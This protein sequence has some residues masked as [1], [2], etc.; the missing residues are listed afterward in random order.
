MSSTS[1]TLSPPLPTTSA[2]TRSADASARRRARRRAALGAARSRGLRRARFGGGSTAPRSAASRFASAALR[3]AGRGGAGRAPSSCTAGAAGELL[4]RAIRVELVAV[5]ADLNLV[6][7][8]RDQLLVGA[9]AADLHDQLHVLPGR[10]AAQRRPRLRPGCRRC[11]LCSS[12]PTSLLTR[13]VLLCRY[14]SS[15]CMPVS[16]RAI[17]VDWLAAAGLRS[18]AIRLLRLRAAP[19]RHRDRGCDDGYPRLLR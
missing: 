7:R 3:C 14:C 10:C 5:G 13:S 1:P 17:C 12:M 9:D 8:D 15:V 2:P 16:L 19:E 6:E 11:G 4:A 18:R